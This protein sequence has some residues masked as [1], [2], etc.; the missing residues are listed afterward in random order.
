MCP[1]LAGQVCNK[2]QLSLRLYGAVFHSDCDKPWAAQTRLFQHNTGVSIKFNCPLSLTHT[3]THIYTNAHSLEI[4]DY[5]NRL[6]REFQVWHGSLSTSS[7]AYDPRGSV[8]EM[9]GLRLGLRLRGR[10][11]LYL[12]TFIG[13][14]SSLLSD[15]ATITGCARELLRRSSF[16]LMSS[17]TK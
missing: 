17:Q 9:A 1:S 4:S 12:E 10:P 11:S 2:E 3:H 13:W 15:A 14:Q 16:L 7:T 6:N 5:I 8:K